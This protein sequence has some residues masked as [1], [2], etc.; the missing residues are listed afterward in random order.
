LAVSG[1]GLI[2]GL[3]RSRGYLYPGL[4]PVL[5]T[6][7]AATHAAWLEELIFRGVLLQG[8]A[9]SWG[10]TTGILGSAGLF[11]VLHLAAPFRLT[12]GWWF[13]VVLGG[14]GLAWTYYAARRSL[15]LP[16]GLHLGFDLWVFLALGLPGETRGLLWLNEGAGQI[17]ADSQAGWIVLL[18]ALLTG[19]LVWV[20][21][22]VER[23]SRSRV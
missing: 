2:L 15:W 20:A 6:L 5:L 8:I 1:G 17:A 19:L 16:L 14:L 21:L 9:R 23:Q 11:T 3:F 4:W 22:S 13:A 18:V 12:P 7:A 10:R